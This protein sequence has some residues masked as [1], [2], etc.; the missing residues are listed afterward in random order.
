MKEIEYVI[1]QAGGRGS[2][3]E[4]LTINKPKC[5]VPIDNK[6]LV[7]HQFEKFKGKKFIIIC[8]YKADV[9]EKYL[10]VFAA[11]VDYKIVK[12]DKKGTCSGI[13]D[14]LKLIPAD[15]PFALVWCDLLFAETTNIP[16]IG[17]KNLVALSKSFECRWSF[18][19]GEFVKVPSMENGVS[20]LF[21]FKNPREL[22]EVN[23]EGEFVLW[24]QNNKISFGA[25]GLTDTREIGTMLSYNNNDSKD[26][27]CRPFNKMIFERN[28]VLKFPINDY[29]KSI[30]VNELNWYKKISELGFSDIPKIFSFEPFSMERIEGRN[31]F[32]YKNFTLS[33]KKEILR[34]IISK[35]SKLHQLLPPIKANHTDCLDNY[36]TKTFDRIS[37]IKNLV[38]FANQEFVMINGR[39]CKNIFYCEESFSALVKK[40]FPSEFNLIHGDPTFSNIMIRNEEVEPVLIDPRGYFGSSKLY[41]DKD[42]DW[43]KLYYSIVGNYDQFNRRNFALEIAEKEVLLRIDSSDWEETKE[44]FFKETGVDENKIKALHALIWLS[45]TTYAWE[46]YDS[47][48][49]SFYNGL[50]YLNEVAQ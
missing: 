10:K 38:P 8:D 35:L 34:K 25:F 40:Y 1:V 21:L 29:G 33:Q 42:Y 22:S 9:L 17:D 24:L 47:V 4:T 12:A 39:K 19:D 43:A 46:D 49:A 31:V 28:R 32:E 5:L 48:C 6:P 45:L 26:S 50:V 36:I 13:K 16:A 15:Q 23:E 14:S 7:F 18:V 3:L 2:R 44:E 41:G 30:A 27:K 37:K 20:G 11:E